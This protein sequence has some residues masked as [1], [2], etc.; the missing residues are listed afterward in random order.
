MF[1]QRYGIHA[2]LENGRVVVNDTNQRWLTPLEGSV[3]EVGRQILH[4]S[5]NHVQD[6]EDEIFCESCHD[7]L[8]STWERNV[9]GSNH[10]MTAV[11]VCNACKQFR[12]YDGPPCHDA[13]MY[14]GLAVTVDVEQ[15]DGTAV[16]ET[17]MENMSQNVSFDQNEY[18]NSAH[19]GSSAPTDRLDEVNAQ[20][21]NGIPQ[22][23]RLPGSREG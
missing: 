20:L 16:S 21:R 19:D 10:K 11:V 17:H 4:R 14:L 9:P 22:P 3:S 23:Q 15:E 6:K 8:L 18:Y 1:D 13:Y 5:H 2:S 7:H 12:L